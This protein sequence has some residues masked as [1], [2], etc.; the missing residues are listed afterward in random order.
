M[1]NTGIWLNAPLRSGEAREETV[2]KISYKTL[3]TVIS[4]LKR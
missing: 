1:V 3:L 4:R 2:G